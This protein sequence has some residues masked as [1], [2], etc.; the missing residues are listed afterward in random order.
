MN[1][2]GLILWSK[3]SL[4]LKMADLTNE[5]MAFLGR[6]TELFQGCFFEFGY[7]ERHFSRSFFFKWLPN[8]H[9]FLEKWKM[10]ILFTK[11]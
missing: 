3:S 9:F 4:L 5:L 7:L 1:I 2:R 10:L 8:L 6:I 11:I